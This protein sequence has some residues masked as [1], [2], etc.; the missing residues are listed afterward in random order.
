MPVGTSTEMPATA[1]QQQ[2]AQ[3]GIALYWSSA[4]ISSRIIC[5]LKALF[6][7]GRFSHSVAKPRGSLISSMVAKEVEVMI[8]S[9][10]T[11]GTGRRW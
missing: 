3:A 8:I 5:A 2:K 9:R 6:L 10:L 4:I 1:T 11:F 7:S